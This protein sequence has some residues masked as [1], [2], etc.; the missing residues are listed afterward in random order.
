MTVHP[1]DVGASYRVFRG[2]S[3]YSDAWVCRAARRVGDVPADRGT[4]LGFRPARR[5][6]SKSL[7]IHEMKL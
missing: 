1:A 3:W 5:F 7:T 6:P 4:S 2:G